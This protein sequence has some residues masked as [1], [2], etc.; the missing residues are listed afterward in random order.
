MLA[1]AI[2]AISFR[3]MYLIMPVSML[4]LFQQFIIEV[5][6]RFSKLSQQASQPTD[7]MKCHE[8][9]QSKGNGNF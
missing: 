8:K 9:G 6:L 5:V 7:M 3:Y 1:Q 4:R 2:A